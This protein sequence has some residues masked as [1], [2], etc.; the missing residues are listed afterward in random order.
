MCFFL[1]YV[2]YSVPC[3]YPGKNIVFHI[4]RGASAYWFSIL[5]EYEDGDDDLREVYLK[6]VCYYTFQFNCTF[7]YQSIIATRFMFEFSCVV[8]HAACTQTLIHG[9]ECNIHGVQIDI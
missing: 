3:K 9:K 4:N 1:C 5:I 2:I 7:V 6:Q 8:L